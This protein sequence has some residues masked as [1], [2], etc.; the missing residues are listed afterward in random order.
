MCGFV[1][2]CAAQCPLSTKNSGI[3]AKMNSSSATCK[4]FLGFFIGSSKYPSAR[5]VPLLLR[6]SANE[7]STPSRKGNKFLKSRVPG[8]TLR[9]HELIKVWNWG[10]VAGFCESGSA[11]RGRALAG[12]DIQPGYR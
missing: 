11:D 9:F 12:H 4:R 3:R 6:R 1:I 7:V 5:V 2:D 8:Q 10:M